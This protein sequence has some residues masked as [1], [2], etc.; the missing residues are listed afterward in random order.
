MI[1]LITTSDLPD[2]VDLLISDLC[3]LDL[4][5]LGAD[6]FG[7]GLY[8]LTAVELGKALDSIVGELASIS[9]LLIGRYKR[10]QGL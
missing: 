10:L 7:P 1:L 3:L 6:V 8:Q 2:A 5:L 4:L 9:K